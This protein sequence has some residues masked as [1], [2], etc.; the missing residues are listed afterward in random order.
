[1]EWHRLNTPSFDSI[2]GAAASA[3]VVSALRASRVSRVRLLLRHLATHRPES[4][5]YI[6]LL[7]EVEAT[8]PAECAAVLT[9]PWVAAWITRSARARHAGPA[10]YLRNVVAAVAYRVGDTATAERIARDSGGRIWLPTIGLFTAPKGI[11]Q[12]ADPI[13]TVRPA[14]RT[15]FTLYVDD[16]D[17]HRDC[18]GVPPADRLPNGEWSRVERT[19]TKAWE[20]IEEHASDRADEL[21]VGLSSVVPL[22][23]VPG[24]SVT[25]GDA[26]GGLAATIPHQPLEAAVMLIHEF[27]HSKINAL[28]DL[29]DLHRQDSGIRYFAPWRPDPRPLSGMLHGIGAFTAVAL[30]W[31][32]FCDTSP[33]PESAMEQ[34]AQLRL[35][36]TCAI[37]QIGDDPGLTAAGRRFVRANSIVVRSLAAYDLPPAADSSARAQ[38]ARLVQR[39][40]RKQ[41]AGSVPQF[42][43]T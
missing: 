9:Y 19:L 14:G 7:A 17:P 26:F 40:Q 11:I 42:E 3:S 5:D 18:V 34:L 31:K 32:A 1:M 28:M 20:L 38:L 33:R 27:Q 4:A 29:V 21:A 2:A 12:P 24:V 37:D 43:L 30:W 13:R 22:N 36:L 23:G 39:W 41:P 35:Q 6:T 16:L 15:G 25:S 8:S 10:D